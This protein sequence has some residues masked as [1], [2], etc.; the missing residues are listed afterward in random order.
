M[1]EYLFTIHLVGNDKNGNALV[2]VYAAWKYKEEQGWRNFSPNE[3]KSLNLGRVIKGRYITT[4]M[5]SNEVTERLLNE[6]G[7]ECSFL[8]L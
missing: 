4:Q 7:D 2:H 5:Y 3:L 6:Y 8:Y 1:K